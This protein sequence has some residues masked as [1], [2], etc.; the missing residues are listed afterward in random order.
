MSKHTPGPWELNEQY[1]IA[2][3]KRGLRAICQWGSYTSEANAALIAAA[4]DLLAVCK[5]LVAHA[6]IDMSLGPAE[7]MEFVR[8]YTDMRAAIAKAEGVS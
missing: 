8:I 5:R 2:R 7:V 4:P 6:G 1:V 3:S